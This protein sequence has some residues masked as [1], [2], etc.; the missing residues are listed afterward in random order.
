VELLLETGGT[1]RL[2]FLPIMQ[3]VAGQIQ[4][5][6][7][8]AVSSKEAGNEAVATPDEPLTNDLEVRRDGPEE[9][10]GDG[11]AKE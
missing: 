5:L 10:S 1:A 7:D 6:I 2:T 9:P 8:D 4:G 11:R 3:D